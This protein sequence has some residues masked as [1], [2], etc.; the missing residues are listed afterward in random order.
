MLWS[1]TLPPNSFRK[2]A[3]LCQAK[4][5]PLA[6]LF[7]RKEG[8]KRACLHFRGHTHAGIT[9]GDRT[10]PAC[11]LSPTFSPV[12]VTIPPIGIASLAFTTKFSSAISN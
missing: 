8:F 2:G 12:M 1:S 6:G 5:C 9:D 4:P 11:W 7:G 10:S 3:D